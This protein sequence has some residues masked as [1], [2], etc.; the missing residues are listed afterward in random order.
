M[1]Y[2]EM[3][4]TMLSDLD[5][6]LQ[7]LERLSLAWILF[8]AVQNPHNFV[9]RDICMET[10]VKVH[11][12]NNLWSDFR[13]QSPS[14]KGYFRWQLKWSPEDWFLKTLEIGGK[15]SWKQLPSDDKQV[16]NIMFP[17]SIKPV[18]KWRALITV[19]SRNWKGIQQWRDGRRW[20]PWV[21]RQGYKTV[22]FMLLFV[23]HA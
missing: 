21:F 11:L 4:L 22:Q 17:N 14:V 23:L 16:F 20:W 12:L 18:M 8:T 7:R 1:V 2:P 19:S 6:K 10:S 15:Q 9:S 13:V 5:T 3:C